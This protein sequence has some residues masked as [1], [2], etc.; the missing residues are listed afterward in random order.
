MKTNYTAALEASQSVSLPVLYPTDITVHARAEFASRPGA[1]W[2]LALGNDGAALVDVS[3]A[4]A[5]P[6]KPRKHR[7]F[8]AYTAEVGYHTVFV[9]RNG[10]YRRINV[11]NLNTYR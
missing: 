3:T 6:G 9:I 7:H 8:C 11:K 1:T 4:R 2:L 5:T 10:N